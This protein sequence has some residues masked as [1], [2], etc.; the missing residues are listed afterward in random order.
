M[1]GGGSMSGGG[2]KV[3]GA[4]AFENSEVGAAIRPLAW[5]WRD[6]SPVNLREWSQLQVLAS[7]TLLYI[8]LFTFSF[9]SSVIIIN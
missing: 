5:A 2:D 7:L 8:I 1:G 9:E 4:W 6:V 3:G